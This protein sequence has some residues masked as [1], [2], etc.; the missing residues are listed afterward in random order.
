MPTQQAQ[1]RDQVR[2]SI[3]L[4]VVGPFA[5]PV[6]QAS[7]TAPRRCCSPTDTV[8]S[9]ASREHQ[10][11]LLGLPHIFLGVS[12]RE[13]ILDEA[14]SWPCSIS[15]ASLGN[16]VAVTYSSTTDCSVKLPGCF[17]CSTRERRR[18]AIDGFEH[19]TDG[20]RLATSTA[21]SSS[22]LTGSRIIASQASTICSDG[23]EPGELLSEQVS[24]AAK[25]N[26][27]LCQ[28]MADLASEE[29]GNGLGHDLQGQRIA[30]RTF[31]SGGFALWHSQPAHARPGSARRQQPPTPD[32]AQ[33][34]HRSRNYPPAARSS[35]GFSRVVSSRQ[36]WCSVSATPRSSR[37]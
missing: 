22:R 28:E 25:D 12:L 33:G 37:A 32:Q 24:D 19:L 29:V 13:P 34:T 17:P 3:A 35:A 10:Q 21:S 14:E 16:Q 20:Q 11:P 26:R 2:R 27:T 7:S 15:L 5:H 23:R 6:E 31:R 9:C 18:S 4:S 1:Q 30:R 8:C 36:L